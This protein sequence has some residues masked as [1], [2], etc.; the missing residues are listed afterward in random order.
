LIKS[1]DG[2]IEIGVLGFVGPFPDKHVVAPNGEQARRFDF[3][4]ERFLNKSLK[5]IFFLQNY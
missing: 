1:F 3:L 5:K 2:A 4:I